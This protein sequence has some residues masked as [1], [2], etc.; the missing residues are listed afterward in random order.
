[1]V[2]LKTVIFHR[3]PSS[4][5]GKAIIFTFSNLVRCLFCLFLVSEKGEN[6]S[7]YKTNNGVCPL[8]YVSTIE[9][10]S[11]IG[12]RGKGERETSNVFITGFLPSLVPSSF[13][14]SSQEMG[15]RGLFDPSSKKVLLYRHPVRSNAHKSTF[16]P[17][18]QTLIFAPCPMLAFPS[19]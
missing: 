5:R 6:W 13:K 4:L 10:L 12:L 15:I 16:L 11:D 2:E 8:F 3:N 18:D 17:F 19:L 1:M 9:M 14:K 7:N